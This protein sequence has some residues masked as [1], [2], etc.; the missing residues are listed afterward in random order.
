M[1]EPKKVIDWELVEK[2]YRANIKTLRQ[3]GEDYSVSHVAIQK[4]AKTYG[5]TRDLALK[6][7]QKAQELVTKRAVT[8]LVTKEKLVTDAQTIQGYGEIVAGVDEL[9]REDL[10]V[11]LGISRSQMNELSTLGRPDLMMGLEQIADMFDKSGTDENG[12]AIVD[13]A[14]ELYRY[15]IS[16]PGRV[17]M[18]KE[19]AGAHGVYIPLQRKVFGLDA[20]DSNASPYE[21]MLRS[22]AA[23][24]QA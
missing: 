5:W 13:K 4:R 6:I 7:Q 1:V 18:A 20:K 22:I 2:H 10:V 15:I 19:I 23:E 3:I 8:K 9:Q 11:A 21:D 16:L 14:N 17:K 12:R 24:S